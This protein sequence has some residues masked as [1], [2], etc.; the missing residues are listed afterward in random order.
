MAYDDLIWALR[1]NTNIPAAAAALGISRQWLYRLIERHGIRFRRHIQLD[2]RQPAVAPKKKSE[3][4]TLR[5]Q[6]SVLTW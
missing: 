4:C 3:V 1:S 2:A 6:S 5:K